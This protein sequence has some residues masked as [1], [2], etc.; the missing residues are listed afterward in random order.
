M[1]IFSLAAAAR[2]HK[3]FAFELSPKSLASLEASI[4]ANGFQDLVS[5]Q[6]VR[7]SA[8][9]QHSCKSNTVPQGQA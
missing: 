6:K 1:G 7:W 3:A 5:V 9:Q 8:E 4:N 2:G